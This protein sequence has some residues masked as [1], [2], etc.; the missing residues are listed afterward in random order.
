MSKTY[1]PSSVIV[2]DRAYRYLTRYQQQLSKSATT[3][4]LV[5]LTDL[6]ACLAAFLQ[7][8]FAPT[9]TK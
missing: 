2:T 3:D 4:Q 5:A 7:K 9:P 6:I 1:V 8:W